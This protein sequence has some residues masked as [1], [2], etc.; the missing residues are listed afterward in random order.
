MKAETS[1]N[2]FGL[3]TDNALITK[4]CNKNTIKNNAESAIA[5]FL[6]IDDF[7]NDSFAIKQFV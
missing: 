6:P 3:I 1:L 2:P 5:N 7:S 4:C